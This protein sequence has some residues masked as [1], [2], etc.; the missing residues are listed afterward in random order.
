MIWLTTAPSHLESVGRHIAAHAAIASV[1]AISGRKNLMAIAIC[2][3]V[4]HLYR[5]LAEEFAAVAH[6]QTY[7]VSIRAQRLKQT[8]SLISHGRLINAHR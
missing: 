5:Y 7:D 3:D 2:R 4:E 6:I 1:A 8:A